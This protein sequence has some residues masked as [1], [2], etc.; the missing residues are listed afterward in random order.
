MPEDNIFITG[1]TVIDALFHVQRLIE[2]NESLKKELSNKFKFLQN[3]KKTILVTG[4]R[5]ESLL[6]KVLKIY[7]LQSRKFQKIIQIHR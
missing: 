6:E 3:N 4:H 7:A 2:T 5:R 1:N